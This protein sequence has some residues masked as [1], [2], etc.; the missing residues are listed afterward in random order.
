MR[1]AGRIQNYRSEFE[2]FLDEFKQQHPDVE[3]QQRA[4]RLLLWDKGPVTPEQIRRASA[5]EVKLKPYVYG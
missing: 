2:I 3:D 1:H 4:G 5:S